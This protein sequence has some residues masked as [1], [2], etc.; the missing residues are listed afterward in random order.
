MMFVTTI[1]MVAYLSFRLPVKGRMEAP[2]L[3]KVMTKKRMEG[4]IT[5]CYFSQIWAITA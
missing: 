1:P 2:N 5:A 4:N 3:A